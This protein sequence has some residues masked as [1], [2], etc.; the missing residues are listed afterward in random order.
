M[1]ACPLTSPRALRGELELAGRKKPDLLEFRTD[2]FAPAAF[3]EVQKRAAAMGAGVIL[4]LKFPSAPP[5][6]RE[7]SWEKSLMSFFDSVADWSILRFVDVGVEAG[8]ARIFEI[9]EM[10][11]DRARLIVSLHDFRVS[12]AYEENVKSVLAIARRHG[13]NAVPKIATTFAS[14]EG[15]ADFVKTV[16]AIP[17]EL[18]AAP[19]GEFVSSARR[20]LFERSLISYAY[21][22]RPN[23]LGQLSVEDYRHG[24]TDS[25]MV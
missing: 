1:I 19:M 17:G 24:L 12:D 21:L 13:G 15:A 25:S 8:E 22:R 23:A 10:V 9:A 2:V 11:R 7:A 18:I 6:C 20:A 5:P 4:A 16:K 14:E 3:P